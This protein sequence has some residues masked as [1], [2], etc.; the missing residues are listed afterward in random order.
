[1]VDAKINKV[2]QQKNDGFN[3]KEVNSKIEATLK[4]A[5]M[6]KVGKNEFVTDF[7]SEK[8]LISNA[9]SYTVKE[10]VYTNLEMAKT[11]KISNRNMINIEE[12]NQRIDTLKN[13]VPSKFNYSDYKQVMS[14][15]KTAVMT[16]VEEPSLVKIERLLNESNDVILPSSIRESNDVALKTKI[17]KTSL[18][19]KLRTDNQNQMVKN[20]LRLQSVGGSIAALR[21]L[22]N[23]TKTATNTRTVS[24]QIN[25]QLNGTQSIQISSSEMTTNT[26]KEALGINVASAQ[27][28][29]IGVQ[30]LQNVSLTERT[31]ISQRLNTDV[32]LALALSSST[33]ILFGSDIKT[34][35]KQKKKLTFILP[36]LSQEN[37]WPTLTGKEFLGI[38]SR[39]VG[40]GFNLAQ[41]AIKDSDELLGVK[42][43]RKGKKQLAF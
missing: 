18:I 33:R 7:T 17:S 12:A 1:M 6:E 20:A 26:V 43:K 4:E 27:T 14:Q 23:K 25:A 10:P 39:D 22:G 13:E 8:P 24:Q 36:L 41:L 34:K 35:N 40:S 21:L 32:A 5:A 38:K 2:I 28:T 19:P 29:D 15:G 42:V 11:V 37:I 3:I 30:T 16:K 9:P 31:G